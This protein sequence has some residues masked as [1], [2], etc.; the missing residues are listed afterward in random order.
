[1]VV[2]LGHI[3]AVDGT[4]PHGGGTV[5]VVAV[6]TGAGEGAA[7]VAAAGQQLQRPQLP[8]VADEVGE[9][10]G[11]AVGVTV[12]SERD[13]QFDIVLEEGAGGGKASKLVEV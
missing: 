10:G 4:A 13:V 6:V 3:E 11:L 2:G 1:V 8:A 5:E 12:V 9:R 7:V